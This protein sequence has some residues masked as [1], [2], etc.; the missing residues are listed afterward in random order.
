MNGVAQCQPTPLRSERRGSAKGAGCV[1]Q[2]R[3][4][5]PLTCVVSPLC[6]RLHLYAPSDRGEGSGVGTRFGC[7]TGPLPLSFAATFIVSTVVVFSPVSSTSRSWCTISPTKGSHPPRSLYERPQIP[8]VGRKRSGCRRHRLRCRARHRYHPK[9]V[10]ARSLC[11][12]PGFAPRPQRLLQR[13]RDDKQA[14][15]VVVLE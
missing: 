15:E 14:N 10:R 5:L 13:H 3:V 12:L 1:R 6:E 7:Y 4:R 8:G 11:P 2:A 9:P